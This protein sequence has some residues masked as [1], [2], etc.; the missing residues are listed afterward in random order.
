MVKLSQLQRVHSR[1][2]YVPIALVTKPHC[3]HILR[4]IHRQLAAETGQFHRLHAQAVLSCTSY[5]YPESRT[6]IAGL[7]QACIWHILSV[8][9]DWC[10]RLSL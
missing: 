5:G 3:I 6:P 8:S 9:V 4:L 7:V 10:T 2:M 1:P